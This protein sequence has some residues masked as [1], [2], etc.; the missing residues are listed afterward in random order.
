M[1][2]SKSLALPVVVALSVALGGSSI[3]QAASDSTFSPEKMRTDA[4]GNTPKAS[5]TSSQ[6]AAAELKPEVAGSP[7]ESAYSCIG[8]V[9]DSG[10]PILTQMGHEMSAMVTDRDSGTVVRPTEGP[11]ANVRRMLSTANAGLSVVP[12]D[13]LLYT[14]RSQDPRLQLAESRLRFIMTIGRK[15]VHVIAKKE[16]K[17]LEDLHDRPVVMG[18]DN[19]A[20]WVVSN[21]LLNLHGAEPSKRIQLKPPAGIKAVLSGEA[22][23]VF[24]VGDIPMK[25]VQKLAEMLKSEEFAAKADEIHML[26][27]GVPDN[28]TEYQPATLN[29]P[30]LA[31]NLK[32]V[33][34]LPTLISYD[35]THKS[36]PYFRQR[37]NELARIGRTVRE[38]LEELR[39]SGHKQWKAT[40]WELEAGNWKKDG[41]FFTEVNGKIAS[42]GSPSSGTSS[43][44]ISE[45]SAVNVR[46]DVREAQNIL[47]SLGYNVGAAD[48]IMGPKT[49]AGLRK[50]QADQSLSPDGLFSADV[51]DALQAQEKLSLAP[52]SSTL[53]SQ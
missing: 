7:C 50:F 9:I 28:V 39:A 44:T 8:M 40:T 19:T 29:Y 17:G 26:E 31:E 43:Q 21:N 41:C 52:N 36:S 30:G 13:M 14:A 32:T 5:K 15:V 45:L 47:N 37:C 53:G 10:D 3:A 22:D 23:A 51:L 18:P 6:I 24:V 16:I 2:H 33:A 48:G 1:P 46:A 4:T 20:L 35:F 25:P 27:V 11:I 12:S 42:G 34:I 38:R 49:S